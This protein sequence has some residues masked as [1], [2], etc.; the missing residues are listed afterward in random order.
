MQKV[1]LA[2]ALKIKNRLVGEIARLRR[3]MVNENVKPESQKRA[4]DIDKLN[5][6]MLEKTKKLLELKTAIA[7]ANI[8]IYEKIVQMEEGKALLTYLESFPCDESVRSVFNGKE[9]VNEKL[10][11]IITREIVEEDYKS[12]KKL[13]EDCQDSIDEYNATTYLE[14]EE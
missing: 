12:L 5:E 4:F 8:N 9:Y 14:I 11:P 1:K 2:K 7:K 6:E 3:Q 10:I 13:I